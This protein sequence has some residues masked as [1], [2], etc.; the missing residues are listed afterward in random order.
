MKT[1]HMK[2]GGVEGVVRGCTSVKYLKIGR[3]NK[4]SEFLRSYMSSFLSSVSIK[5][6]VKPAT[7][8]YLYLDAVICLGFGKLEKTKRCNQRNQGQTYSS[9]ILFYSQNLQI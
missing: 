3:K 9:I 1:G 4:K 2:L 7:F 6:Y 5:T 8:N